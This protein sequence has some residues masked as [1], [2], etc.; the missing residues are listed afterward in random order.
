V[1]WV[2]SITH[3][4]GFAAAVAAPASRF[5]SLGLDVETLVAIAPA[6]PGGDRLRARI[7]D[8]D[9]W[10]CL[11]SAMPGRSEADRFRAVFSA[12]EALYKCLHPLVGEWFDFHDARAVRAS[13]D[14]ITLRLVRTLGGDAGARFEAGFEL[15]HR[16]AWTGEHVLTIATLPA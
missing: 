3:T 2:G 12:K 11:A 1:G 6:P 8:D 16:L 14:A 15:V 7:A 13:P 5:R 10:S 9:E 4:G